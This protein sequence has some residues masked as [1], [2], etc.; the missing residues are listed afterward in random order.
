MTLRTKMLQLIEEERMPPETGAVAAIVGSSDPRLAEYS[1]PDVAKEISTAV[2][3][4]VALI[5]RTALLTS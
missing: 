4:A 1:I 3:K 5:I 2:Q